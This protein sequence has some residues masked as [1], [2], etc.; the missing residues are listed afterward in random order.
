MRQLDKL[1]L[2]IFELVI[3]VSI[4]IS[5]LGWCIQCEGTLFCPRTVDI[6]TADN[7]FF[8]DLDIGSDDAIGVFVGD[9]DAA[10]EI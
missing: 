5:C 7:M 6:V 4:M 8:F 2:I 10:S 1:S 3:F 9:R